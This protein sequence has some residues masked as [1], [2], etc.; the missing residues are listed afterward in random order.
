[1]T[2]KKP[3][4]YSTTSK[5]LQPP[6]TGWESCCIKMACEPLPEGRS[7]LKFVTLAH[8]QSDPVMEEIRRLRREQNRELRELRQARREMETA[9]EE[10]LSE[11]QPSK[12]APRGA[13][14]RRRRHAAD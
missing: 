8:R 6:K 7:M 2:E 13:S 1:L 4:C 9:P 3:E 10:L 11:S 5:S 12:K 14:A